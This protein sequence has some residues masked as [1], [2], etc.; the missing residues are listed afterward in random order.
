MRGWFLGV[1][2]GLSLG[3]AGAAAAAPCAYTGGAA[4]VELPG[5]PFM[6]E[7]TADGCWLFVSMGHLEGD[8]MGSG[9]VAV[10]RNEAG[11]FR[12]MGMTP[13]KDYP[14]GLALSHDGRTLAVATE[15]SVAI[16]DVARLEAGEAGAVTAVLPAGAGA[17]YLAIS[18]DDRL[19]FVSEE[20]RARVSVIDFAKARGVGEKA[21]I[22]VIAVG[23]APVGLAMSTDGARLYVTSESV[24]KEVFEAACQP[25]GGEGRQHP[26]GVL[27]VIDVAQAGKDPAKSVVGVR[28]AGCNPV[29]VAL[30]PDESI[31]W[32]TA[33]GEDRLEG[34]AA[35]KLA[36]A[37]AAAPEIAVK[38]G[39]APIGI[40]VRPD[41]QQIW[42]ADSNRFG[43]NRPGLLTVVSPAGQVLRTAAT[44]L[45][46]RDIRF[47]PDGKTLVVAQYGSR[48]VQFVPT[49]AP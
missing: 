13:L 47:L 34:F 5:R 14:G 29:R 48:A 12:V 39:A 43:H 3:A 31:A 25:E 4:T 44:G 45:F 30:A 35:R 21:E 8:K 7:S 40:A 11:R 6:A 36:G 32:V 2:A 16:L 38:V 42:I 19:L 20:R 24:G 18:R 1:L 23:R 46:P 15:A 27:T 49:D 26:E 10:L 9:G 41:G 28:K 37:S 17:I 33:R 22:G